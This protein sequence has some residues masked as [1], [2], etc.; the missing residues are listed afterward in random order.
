MMTTARIRGGSVA[1]TCLALLLGFPAPAGAQEQLDEVVVSARKRE[2]S[3]QE[4]PLSVAVFNTEALRER[5]IQSV[6]DVATFT[7][8]FSFQRNAVGRRLDA[9]SIRGQF[10][11]LQNFGSEG[12]VAFYVDGAYVSGTAGGLTV[13]NLERVEVLRGPQ[14]AQFGRGAFAGAINYVTK[15]PNDK[16]LEGELYL[17][18]GEENDFKASGYLSGPLAGDKLL[19][20]ASASWESFDGEWQNTMNPCKAGQT[21]ADGC[22][23]FL[24]NYKAF[25]PNGQPPSTVLDDFTPLGGESTWNVTGKLSWRPTE[26]LTF[27]VKGEY[28]EADDE[29]FASLYQP[30][31]NCYVAGDPDDPRADITAPTSPGWRCGE[32]TADGLRALIGIADL[33]EGVTSNYGAFGEPTISTPPAPFIGTRTSS[34]RYLAEA[35]LDLGDWD[36]AVVGTINHQELE[37]YRDLDRTPW[38]GPVWSNVFAAGELQTWDDYSGEVRLTSPQDQPVRGTTGVYY[39]KADNESYQAEYTGFCNRTRFGDPY[40]NGRPSWTLK[41]EKENLGFFGGLDYDVGEDVTLSVEARYAKDSPV[42][43]APNGV[44]AKENYYSLTP[45]FIAS[46]Q[47][48]DD[49]NVYASAAKGNKPGGFFFGFF[50]APVTAEHTNEAIANGKA[51]IKEE[52]AWTYELGA[53]TQWLDRRLTANVAVYYI[54]WTNQ[55]INE[56]QNIDWTCADTGAN[57]SIPNNFIRNAGESQVTGTE[58]ELALAATDNLFLTLNYGLQD[59]KLESYNSLILATL[60][61]DDPDVLAT[62]VSVAGNEAPR[63]PKHTVTASAMYKRPLGG[64][65]SDWFLRGDY[66]W[67]SKTWLEAENEAYVGDVTLVNARI[68]VE[69]V[70]WTAAFYVDNLLEEDAPLLVSNFPSFERFPTVVNAF[71]IVPRRGRNAGITLTRRF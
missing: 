67:N 37:S 27:N 9:P 53:K 57:S 3:L 35:L 5:N 29:H 15:S 41:A 6:Y 36:L 42:Q 30:E 16:E 18:A 55:A 63:V 60:V 48:T 24:N 7:P 64:L 46:W 38:L 43:K 12:N 33:R 28:T 11:P 49:V 20:V 56:V 8:N 52:K 65:G 4:V 68:G 34:Q 13:D 71:H 59:T 40:I 19:F 2:E 23:S 25:W 1:A 39:F 26:N 51:I 10:T 58:I 54:D 47:A 17:K 50:D 66:V 32:I 69:S 21:A 22:V 31:L 44:T 61:S 70:N 14:V 62:G 45:R